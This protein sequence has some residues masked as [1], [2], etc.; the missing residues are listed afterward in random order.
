MVLYTV[1][2]QG[3]RPLVLLDPN[4]F[5]KDGTAALCGLAPSRDGSLLAFGTAQ[6]G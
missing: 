1:D 4:T 6:A 2:A 5:R 3:N